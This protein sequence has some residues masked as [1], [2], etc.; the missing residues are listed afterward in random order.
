[1]KQ[2]LLS[3]WLVAA[4]IIM[5]FD[6]KADE[7]TPIIKFHSDAYTEVGA[8]NSFSILIGAD[9]RGMYFIH[10][11]RG[12]RVVEVDQVAVDSDGFQGNWISI[13]VG[14]SGE[15]EILGDGNA[16]NTVVIDGGYVTQIDLSGCPHLQVLSLEHNSL[17]ELDLTPYTELA[18]IYLTD[19]PFTA[20]SPLKIGVPKP[21]LQILEIDIVDHLDQS[22]NLSDYPEMRAFDGYANRDLWNLDPTGC[23]ELLVLSCEMSNVAQLDVTKN[24][25]LLRLNISETRVKEIDLSKNQQLEHFIAGHSSGSVNTGY[26]LRDVD[27]SHN[28]KLTMVEL[29]GS[30]LTDIDFSANPELVN[31]SLSHNELRSLDLS[32]N[33]KVASLNVMHNDM[34][35]ATLPS[36]EGISE[37]FYLQDAMEVPRAIEVG[38]ALDLSARVLRPDTETSAMVYRQR[39]G[40]DP[41]PLDISY[42]SYADGVVTFNRAL[43]DS[44][45]VKYSN[46]LLYEYPLVTKPFMV[47][48]AEDYG[49]PSKIATITSVSGSEI[50]FMV[51]MA[52]ASAANAKQFFVDFGDGVLKSFLTRSDLISRGPNVTGVPVGQLSIYIPEGEVMTS[53][54]IKDI[55]VYS[56]DLKAATELSHLQLSGCGLYA[57]DLRYNRCLQ[58]LDIS[59]NNLYSLDLAGV[60]GDYEKNVLSWIDAKSNNI[61]TFNNMAP[62]ACEYLDLSEN[63]L[64]ELVLKDYDRLQTLDVSHNQLEGNLDMT[65][66][67]AA[68]AVRAANNNYSSITLNAEN[69]PEFLDIRGCR[70]TL[71]TLPLP[72]AELGEGYSYAPQQRIEI[73]ERVTVVNLSDQC[74]GEVGANTVFAWKNTNGEQLVVGK[75]YTIRN[76]VT[77]FINAEAGSVYCE[78]TNSFYSALSGDNALLTTEA[79]IAPKPS[80]KLASFSTIAENGDPHFIVAGYEPT[81]IFIDWKGDGTLDAY[82]VTTDATQYEAP[83]IISK[84]VSVYAY[85][86]EEADKF[87]VFSLYDMALKN[88]DLSGFTRLSCIGLG[89]A[90]LTPDE[91]TLPASTMLTELNLSGNKFKDYPYGESH[92]NVSYLVLSNNEL[93]SFDASKLPAL[94]NL[95]LSGNR[96]TSVHFDNPDI[97]NLMLDCNKLESVDLT[98]LPGLQQLFLNSNKLTEVDLSALPALYALSLVDNAFTYATLPVPADMSN[99]MVYYYGNQAPIDAKCE[100]YRVDLSAQ[101][102]AGGY[103]TSYSWY[104]GVPEYNEE[105]GEI[106]GTLLEEGVDYTISDGVTT[107]LTMPAEEVICLMENAA[108]PNLRLV[109]WPL[110]VSEVESVNEESNAQGEIYNLQGM[111][112]ICSPEHLPAGVYIVN[113]KKIIINN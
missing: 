7:T 50:S 52:G 12:S 45:Y 37:Y 42:Y 93:E 94:T 106:E 6:A 3:I 103:D 90:S 74:A 89:N 107:F 71:A 19:N 24:S 64:T 66:L 4:I 100:D 47:K 46:T 56:I 76:G 35:F 38:S 55:D 80:Y 104:L 1:M 39:I 81:Q 67:Y 85:D 60:A 109:T 113:G 62:L 97:W 58:W 92:P 69:T 13:N 21:N 98:G 111:R 14:E 91:L 70:F 36:P 44:V 11:G 105:T 18:A 16:I 23:P 33:N 63:Q 10:D 77:T 40:S 34:D 25:K 86:G 53:L 73:P 17:Q 54:Y 110:Q 29:N 43:T 2:Y 26:Y 20:A 84:D 48:S 8:S 31:I 101:A 102:H 5:A 108:F 51:G 30:H 65:Y 49:K 88:V 72:S 22:F 83:M 112:M 68:T 28:P 9:T 15:V 57:L 99:L 27:L 79:A 96:L 41:E 61:S 82:E 95:I 78:I 75:D 87:S 59:R 32:N